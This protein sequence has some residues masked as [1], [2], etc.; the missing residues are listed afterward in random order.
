M[1]DLAPDVDSKD[2]PSERRGPILPA[3]ATMVSG[4]DVLM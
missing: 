1:P 2:E 4:P 3:V